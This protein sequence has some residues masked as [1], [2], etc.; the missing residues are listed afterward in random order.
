MTL[1]TGPLLCGKLPSDLFV[2]YVGY[3][4]ATRTITAWLSSSLHRHG[5]PSSIIDTIPAMRAAAESVRRQLVDVPLEI[6][7]AF[8]ETIKARAQLTRFFR[9]SQGG[10]VETASNASHEFFT[11]R[12]SPRLPGP[13]SS[14]FD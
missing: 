11:N 4:K 9:K 2:A 12:Y 14:A 1:N 7:I 5:A 10:G 8:E 6:K 3:K 13:H